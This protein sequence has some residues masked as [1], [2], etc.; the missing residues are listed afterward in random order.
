[1]KKEKIDSIE[2]IELNQKTV[3]ELCLSEYVQN[4]FFD[5][6][7][8]PEFKDFIDKLSKEYKSNNFSVDLDKFVAIMRELYLKMV[9]ALKTYMENKAREEKLKK[10]EQKKL[11]DEKKKKG[12]KK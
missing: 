7:T 12:K 5:E 1:M 4:W 9:A 3:D 2:K 11:E 10:L 8:T 6:I